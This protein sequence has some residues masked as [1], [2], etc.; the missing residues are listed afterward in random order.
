MVPA[1]IKLHKEDGSLTLE[2][3]DGSH[4]ILTGEY[5]RVHSPSAEV[6]GHG[7]GQEVLQYGKHGIKISSIEP[8]GNYAL[9]LTFSDGH[10]TGIYSWDY[11]YDLASNH[12]Q[13]WDNY[14]ATL[15]RAGK[16]R[17]ANIQVVQLVDPNQL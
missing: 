10:D 17:E 12:N 5:L 16:H 7:K 2:Y 15:Q 1:K 3:A 11:L 4:F 13:H 14:L 6:R 8:S 9:R